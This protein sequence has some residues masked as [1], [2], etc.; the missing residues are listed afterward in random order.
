MG[1]Q[2]R[3]ARWYVVFPADDSETDL[4]VRGFTGYAEAV[5]VLNGMVLLRVQGRPAG[6]DPGIELLDFEGRVLYST[7]WGSL[8]RAPYVKRLRSGSMR[9]RWDQGK[10][11]YVLVV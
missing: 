8:G 11:D 9:L 2:T 10:E 1:K 7:S 6:Y 5:N 4:V 3:P